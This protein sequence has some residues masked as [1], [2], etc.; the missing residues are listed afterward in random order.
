MAW[1][2][3]KVVVLRKL[4]DNWGLKVKLHFHQNITTVIIGKG[5]ISLRNCRLQKIWIKMYVKSEWNC[6]Y[7]HQKINS[8]VFSIRN[9]FAKP[10][11][12]A[13]FYFTYW[14]RFFPPQFFVNASL[15]P[16]GVEIISS[17]SLITV[18]NE[19]YQ[20]T[21]RSLCCAA[22]ADEKKWFHDTAKSYPGILPGTRYLNW[23]PKL[24]IF[25]L[26]SWK[27][28]YFFAI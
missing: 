6:L 4:W 13:I 1:K 16:S 24:L 26:T 7:S 8:Q 5:D 2:Q 19:F 28:N 11:N 22:C 12:D 20:S 18:M 17:W 27:L 3:T 10:K 14:K 9:G 25:L 21:H 23:F 15:L